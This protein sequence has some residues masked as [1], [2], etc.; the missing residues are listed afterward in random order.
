MVMHAVGQR[1]GAG[2][3]QIVDLRQ[4]S[5]WQI[6]PLLAEEA[7]HW[8]EDLR[9]DYRTSLELIKKFVDLYSPRSA[10]LGWAPGQLRVLRARRA[11]RPGRRPVRLSRVIR[12]RN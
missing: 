6:E 2:S 7:R 8:R 11:Q 5:S 10:I 9:W 1:L 12:S 3:M 4:L